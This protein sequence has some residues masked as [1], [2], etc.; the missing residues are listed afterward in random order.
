MD[1]LTRA[2][3][4]SR[5]EVSYL[6]KKEKAFQDWFSEIMEKCHPAD[7]QRVRPWGNIGD[8]KNDG[9]LK[10]ER[11]LFQVYAPNEMTAAKAIAKIDEDFNEALPYWRMFFDIWAFVHN[12]MDGLGPDITEKLLAL[13]ATN[14]PVKLLPW[15]FEELRQRVFKLNDADLYSL[16]GPAPTNKELLN[17]RFENLQVVLLT[18]AQQ[19]PPLNPT[20]G[21]V[22]ADKIQING[23]S[24]N[25]AI[26]LNAGRQKSDLVKQFFDKWH[27]PMFGDQIA[28]A[29]RQQYQNLKSSGLPPDLIFY[30]LQSYAGG[31]TLTEPAIQAAVLAVLAFYFEQCDIFEE[32]LAEDKPLV[33]DDDIPSA[34]TSDETQEVSDDPSD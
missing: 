30:E 5:F 34:P 22:P 7:F 32:R 25:V 21:P 10:S 29:F 3:Y 2:Y 16:L 20:I 4:E 19:Q 31:T 1:N 6:K 15:G 24:N 8:R 33:G 11:M 28:E 26:L 18:I 12:S 17:L 27:D 13:E 9:Y 23:L 14:E